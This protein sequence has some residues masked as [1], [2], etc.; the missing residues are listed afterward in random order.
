MPWRDSTPAAPSHIICFYWRIPPKKQS[1]GKAMFDCQKI[2]PIQLSLNPRFCCILVSEQSIFVL[3]K[4]SVT[5][6]KDLNCT[7]REKWEVLALCLRLIHLSLSCWISTTSKSH[8]QQSSPVP[9]KTLCQHRPWY[10]R[11]IME[12]G[13]FSY[14]NAQ[15]MA[16]AESQ[17]QEL[18]EA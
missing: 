12:S 8:I 7:V 11:V 2:S 3:H 18:L 10:R 6:M 13:A 5:C 14:W 17:F 4:S 16:D 9:W 15:P 1:F